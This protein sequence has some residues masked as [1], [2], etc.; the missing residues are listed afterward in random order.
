MRPGMEE[1]EQAEDRYGRQNRRATGDCDAER[2]ESS[3]EQE[4]AVEKS[5][6]CLYLTRTVN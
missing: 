2:N 1:P 3:E 6:Y 4:G 5:R